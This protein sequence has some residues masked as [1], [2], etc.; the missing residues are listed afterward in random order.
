MSNEFDEEKVN[1][2]KEAFEMFDKDHD[3][4]ISL[5]EFL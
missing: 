5:K 3:G 4:R 2:I 1:E